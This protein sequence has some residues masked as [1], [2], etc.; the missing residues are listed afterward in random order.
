VP[1]RR[2]SSSHNSSALRSRNDSSS[3]GRLRPSLQQRLPGAEGPPEGCSTAPRHLRRSSSHFAHFLFD[4]FNFAFVLRRVLRADR[5][6]LTASLSM[7]LSFCSEWR[8]AFATGVVARCCTVRRARRAWASASSPNWSAAGRLRPALHHTSQYRAIPATPIG[9]T[10][11]QSKHKHK[12]KVEFTNKYVLL[13]YW[14]SVCSSYVH[15]RRRTADGVCDE[16]RS[17]RGIRV[18]RSLP[19]I[20]SFFPARM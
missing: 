19:Q 16:A 15:S 5:L 14:R 8:A 20:P 9:S 4:F 3:D 7:R 17:E 11:A 6:P 12:R 18:I 13:A 10:H 1:S 2:P